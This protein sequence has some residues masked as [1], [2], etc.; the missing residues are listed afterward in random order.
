MTNY[1]LLALRTE[2]DDIDRDLQTLL[3]QRKQVITQIAQLKKQ[4]QLA[5]S[6][7]LREAEILQARTA[8]VADPTLQ[9]WLSCIFPLLFTLGRILQQEAC[10]VE[11]AADQLQALQKLVGQIAELAR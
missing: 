6:D 7:P 2:L 11:I 10:D 9:S 5:I 1:E 4:Q 8:D 3:A